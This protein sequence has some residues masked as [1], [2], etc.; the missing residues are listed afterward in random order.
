MHNSLSI[1]EL[2]KTVHAD[3]LGKSR[4]DPHR[5]VRRD[6]AARPGPNDLALDLGWTVNAALPDPEVARLLTDD[7]H[8]FLR[9]MGAQP[10]ATSGHTIVFSLADRLSARAFQI[11]C[12]PR[13]IQVMAGDVAGLWAG[14]AWMEREMR[15]RRGPF[16]PR[17]HVARS[18]AWPA[19]IS[20]GPWLGNYSVP[21][22]SPEYL[23]DDALRLYAHY[24]VNSMMIYGDMLCY[25]K[26]EL[27]PELNHP[28]ADR[29]LATLRDA[30]RRAARYGVR[31]SYV[32]VGP[33]LLADHPVFRAHPSARGAGARTRVSG[34]TIHFLCSSDETVLAFYAEC[35]RRLCR[36]APELLS[37]ILI[38]YAESF[39]HCRMWK[40]A[41]VQPCPRCQARAPHEVVAGQVAAV[42]RGIRAAGSDAGTAVWVYRWDQGD[43]RELFRCLPP[44]TAVFHHVENGGTYPRDGYR[45]TAWDYSVDCI[46]PTPEMT[47]LAEFAH[48]EKR[49][50]F[51]KTETGGGLEVFQFPYI[52]AMQRLAEKWQVVRDLKPDGVHQS[53]LFFGMFG[54]R[55]E[56]MGWWAAY[57]RDQ[58]AAE[59][60]RRMAVRDFGPEAAET[61]LAA[62]EHMSR[63]VQHLPCTCFSYYYIGPSFLGPAHPLVPE[64]ESPIPEVFHGHLFYL[65]EGEESFSVRRIEEARTCLA[66]TALPEGLKGVRP[67]DP[68]TPVWD[69]VIREYTRAADEAEAACRRLQQ[70]TTLTRTTADGHSLRE[71]MALTE[72]AY[73][74]FRSCENTARFLLAR[75]DFEQSGQT[76]HRDEMRRVALLERENA[77]SALPLYQAAPWLDLARRIDG[78]FSPCVRMIEEKVKWIDRFLDSANTC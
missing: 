55:A 23:D 15:V 57:E 25:V 17:G 58:P 56:E 1:R 78:R 26:S 43:R 47:E 59:F 45:K 10:T 70:A 9:R 24:G 48:R 68:D 52:P 50:L 11:D 13:H 27:L 60:L 34:D 49:P 8:D 33:K 20:Q 4:R 35:F 63:A 67:D 6:P 7:L 14:L 46:G 22:L 61:V 71:E 32:V 12:Q 51:V 31:F 19:Q 5:D 44:D 16:L 18:A 30:A 64:R 37:F 3:P 42:E 38:V 73:R 75:R 40:R 62:W 69:I 53:W 29:H 54:S 28:E 77:L 66:L 36:E 74:T 72:L 65:Q 76:L 39:Y 21:D 41:D 2:L